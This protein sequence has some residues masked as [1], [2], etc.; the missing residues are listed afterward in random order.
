[1]DVKSGQGVTNGDGRSGTGRADDGGDV[2]DGVERQSWGCAME[3]LVQLKFAERYY[4]WTAR[5]NMDLCKKGKKIKNTMMEMV[6]L[7]IVR[8]DRMV[9]QAGKEHNVATA[10][11]QSCLMR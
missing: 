8:V 3:L 6:T 5:G 7:T 10:G 2:S 4:K 1:M 9:L 11:G